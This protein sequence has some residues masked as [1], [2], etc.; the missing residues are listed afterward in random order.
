MILRKDVTFPLPGAYTRVSQFINQE[1]PMRILAAVASMLVLPLAVVRA[2]P[3]EPQRV[4]ADA[5]WVLHVDMDT[6]R[7][8]SL[9]KLIEK[10][11]DGNPQLQAQIE[12]VAQR[13]GMQFP[14]DVFDV[15]LYSH[16]FE[17]ADTVVLLRATTDQQGVL[18]LLQFSPS[19]SSTP[20]GAHTIVSW[21]DKGKVL[22][23]SYFQDDEI[24]ISQTRENVE[25]ALDL[26]DGKGDALPATMPSGAATSGVLGYVA[27]SGL[28]ALKQLKK[29]ES[30]LIEQIDSAWLSLS[31]ADEDAMVRGSVTAKTPQAALQMHRTVEGLRAM[32]ALFAAGED[33]DL[34]TRTAADALS[35]LKVTAEGS[36]LKIEWPMSLDLIERLSKLDE[37]PATQPAK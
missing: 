9:W 13:T 10:R 18:A 37:Q 20:H 27:G 7:T 28:E 29:P 14:D 34:K 31:E 26:L 32:L 24:V 36:V 25:A 5:K 30:P 4:P 23:G 16:S 35:T 8:S 17:E 1:I 6:V 12:E 19:Y 33:A 11:I 21:D 22:Y 3:F 2:E 15:T